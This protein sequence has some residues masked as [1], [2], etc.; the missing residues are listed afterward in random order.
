VR[1]IPLSHEANR[2]N[3]W[4]RLVRSEHQKKAYPRRSESRLYHGTPGKV[5]LRILSFQGPE[6]HFG[7]S[8]GGGVPPQEKSPEAPGSRFAESFGRRGSP[9][10]IFAVPDRKLCY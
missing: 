7:L 5:E 6:E 1:E 3:R 2:R 10:P 4:R 9:Q 8:E